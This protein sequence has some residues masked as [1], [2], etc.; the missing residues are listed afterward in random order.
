MNYEL[1]R[2][3]RFVFCHILSFALYVPNFSRL[4]KLENITILYI[5]VEIMIVIICSVN[6]GAVVYSHIVS[7]YVIRREMDYI[8]GCL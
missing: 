4:G 2:E 3:V 6:T 5:L 1:A 7:T 8:K